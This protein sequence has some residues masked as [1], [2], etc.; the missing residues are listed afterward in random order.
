MRRVLLATVGMLALSSAG[1]L[2][3]DLPRPVP[4][5]K[6]PVTYTP[7]FTWTGFY[8]GINGGYGFG[9][10]TWSGFATDAEPSGALVGLTLGYNWQTGPWV[11]GLEGDIDWS[12]MRDRFA[13][14]ACPAG[15]ETR[16]NWLG[17]ARGRV[18][19]AFDRVMP[20]LTGGLAVGDVRAI[21]TGLT[22]VR[23]TNAGW[24]AGGGV[25]AAITQNLTAKLEYR[26]VDLGDVGCTAAACGTPTKVDFT[27]N[28]IRGGINFKF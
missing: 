12:D 19:Y 18:G 11:F 9:N 21:P 5:A 26:Y 24:T 15:C 16:N 10:S 13:S 27:A 1:A 17:T 22:G 2:A 4:A 8:V 14:A 3:A 6:A 28:V 25:E 7:V 23:E 20:Y